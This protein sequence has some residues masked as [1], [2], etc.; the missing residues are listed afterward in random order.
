M[1]YESTE[2]TIKT[3][4]FTKRC[5]VKSFFDEYLKL[6][7]DKLMEYEGKQVF[8][9]PKDGKEQVLICVWDNFYVPLKMISRETYKDIW[10]FVGC[11]NKYICVTKT[12]SF[13]VYERFNLPYSKYSIPIKLPFNVKSSGKINLNEDDLR[14]I[15][16]LVYND[17]VN[18]DT[19]EEFINPVI[20][21]ATPSYLYHENNAYYIDTYKFCAYKIP[22]FLGNDI[23]TCAIDK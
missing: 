4:T 10:K 14:A 20:V 21:D 9:F 7:P 12:H 6:F 8:Q 18:K 17:L 23:Q 1:I 15:N 2:I 19:L 13:P 22:I 16:C 11:G 3:N 5:T